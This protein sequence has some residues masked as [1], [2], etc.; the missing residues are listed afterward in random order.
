MS[1]WNVCIGNER[2]TLIYKKHWTL[3]VY[4]YVYMHAVYTIVLT[5]DL[6]LGYYD[7][8][9]KSTI[10]P[11]IQQW[12]TYLIHALLLTTDIVQNIR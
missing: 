5:L 10:N 1:L 11:I 2:A 3:N 12:Y 7:T 6:R 4:I 8:I 9:W